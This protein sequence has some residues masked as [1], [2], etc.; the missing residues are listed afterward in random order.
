MTLHSR[1]RNEYEHL[2]CHFWRKIIYNCFCINH[3][4]KAS[5]GQRNIYAPVKRVRNPSQ[6]NAHEK[7]FVYVENIRYMYD[8]TMLPVNF[9]YK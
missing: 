6:A 4:S 2:S 5:A 9:D 1:L 3:I 8:I 7:K